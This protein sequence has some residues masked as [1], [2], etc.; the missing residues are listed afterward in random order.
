MHN[1]S[2]QPMGLHLCGGRMYVPIHNEH[3]VVYKSNADIQCRRRNF[4]LYD[5][6]AYA[7]YSRQRFGDFRTN[8]E[9]KKP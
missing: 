4:A 3:Y 2:N 6:T 9:V 8:F 7:T 1:D 5:E